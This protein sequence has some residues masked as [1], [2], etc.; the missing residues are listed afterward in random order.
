MIRDGGRG[1]EIR[2]LEGMQRHS[3]NAKERVVVILGERSYVYVRP[4]GCI[5]NTNSRSL[6]LPSHPHVAVA[7]SSTVSTSRHPLSPGQGG[8]AVRTH[9]RRRGR[10]LSGRP[11]RC[12]R[13]CHRDVGQTGAPGHRDWRKE[14]DV[15][16]LRHSPTQRPPR[17]RQSLSYP[18]L[19]EV[20]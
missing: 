12:P 18:G 10:A 3:A 19:L 16:G 15:W 4:R 7:I 17:C 2:N 11:P 5:G 9:S 6:R 13:L 1:A 8:S 20:I 14:R